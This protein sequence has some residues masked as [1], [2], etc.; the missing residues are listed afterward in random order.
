MSVQYNVAVVG[1]GGYTGV[2]LIKILL[3]H[4][5]FNLAYLSSSQ[6]GEE[7]SDLYPALKGVFSYKLKKT[8]VKEIADTCD[9]AFLALPHKNAMEVAKPLLDLGVKVVDLSADY[10]LRLENYEA[11]YTRHSDNEH[12][13]E[14]VYGLVEIYKDEIQKARLIANPGCYPTATL[15]ALIPFLPYIE[16]RHSLIIDAKSGVSGAGKKCSQKTHYVSINENIFAY[17]P[18]KHRHAIEIKEKLELLGKEIYHINFVPH[19]LPLTRGMLVSIY[20]QLQT[21]IDPLE[22]LEDFYAN[23]EFI[24]IK[25]EPVDVKSVAGTHFCDI[26][27]QK[28]GNTLFISSAID[29]LLRGA[30]SQ[31]VANANL[32]M[33]L[34][35]S[36]AMPKIAAIP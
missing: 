6:G 35:A 23:E 36:I 20:A 10:R 30:S 12:L 15:L 4:P 16:S 13:K 19:L 2:E 8:D 5:H 27:A 24:R 17:N 28:H 33:G 14:A 26:Y 7:I 1:A 34:D 3:D 29:N 21:D 32:M 9:L 25:R 22:V 31:A 11:F 18:L